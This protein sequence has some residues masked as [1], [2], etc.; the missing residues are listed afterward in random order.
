MSYGA[1]IDKAV[2]AHGKW[3]QRL[4]DAVQ[5][6]KSEFTVGN[7]RV[8]DRCEFGKWFYA[9]PP[10]DRNSPIGK[11]VQAFH[12][13]FHAEAARLLD[14]ALQGK[15]TEAAA[16]LSQQAQFTVIAGRLALALQKWKS[17]AG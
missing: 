16:G 15:T 6:G 10:S 13:E 2:A 14:L 1:D 8:D 7:V 11:Q 12:A 5:T 3:K 9:L 4:I 17:Q